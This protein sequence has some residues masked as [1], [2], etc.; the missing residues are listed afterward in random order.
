MNAMDAIRLIEVGLEP[1]EAYIEEQRTKLDEVIVGYDGRDF[2]L[3]EM[4]MYIR[5]GYEALLELSK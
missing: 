2:T 4:A 1:L 5:Q 3:P